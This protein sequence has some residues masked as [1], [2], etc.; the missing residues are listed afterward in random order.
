MKRLFLLTFCLM[1]ATVGAIGAGSTLRVLQF[2]IRLLTSSDNENQWKYRCEDL[3][4]YCRVVNPDVIGMQEVTPTQRTYVIANLPDYA[5]V[6]LG[7]DGGQSGEHCPVFYRKDLFTLERSGTFWLSDT[8]EKVSNTW[9]AACRR[10]V[11]WTILR[12]KKTGERFLYAN[13][14]FD[15]QNESAR[16]KS[17]VLCKQKLEEYAQGLPII[18]TGDYNC[19]PDSKCYAL[20]LNCEGARPMREVWESARVKEGPEGTFHSW[21]TIAMGNRKRI[22]FIFVTPEINVLRAVTDDDTKRPR[23]LSDHDPVFADVRLP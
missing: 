9:G 12:N 1:A 6:G 11:T 4:S 17:S 22:D 10:I 13:T 23:M 8:P 19:Y 21:G 5:C 7:R 3:I 16:D 20:M 14:H 2:N 18:I 15:H